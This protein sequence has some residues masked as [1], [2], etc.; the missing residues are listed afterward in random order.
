[1]DLSVFSLV[2]NDVFPFNFFH[3]NWY[4]DILSCFFFG[5]QIILLVRIEID[6]LYII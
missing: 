6:S 4:L 3:I 1:M 2:T 5:K